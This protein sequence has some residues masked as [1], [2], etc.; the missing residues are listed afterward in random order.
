[1]IRFDVLVWIVKIIDHIQ[2]MKL[3]D[4]CL[5]VGLFVHIKHGIFNSAKMHTFVALTIA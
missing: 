2:L 3:E 4:I 5:P 1:M